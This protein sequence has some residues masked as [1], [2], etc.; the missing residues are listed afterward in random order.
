[1][2]DMF[3]AG[4]D[5]HAAVDAARRGG[6]VVVPRALTDPFRRRLHSEL[7]ELPFE[8][9]PWEVGPVLQEAEACTLRD[10]DPFPVLRSLVCEFG[11]RVRA[12]GREPSDNGRAAIRGLATWRPNEFYVQRYRPGSLGITSH[13]D[14][15]RYRRLIALFTA[16]GWGRLTVRREREGEVLRRFPIRPGSLV[17][18][19]APGLSGFRDARPFHAVEPLGRAERVSVGLRMNMRVAPSR[20]SAGGPAA[21]VGLASGK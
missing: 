17:M 5:L 12:L 1:M 14:G 15:R 11:A 18:L 7:A 21:A 3:V 19:R 2:S 8:P 9:V 10:L 4:L 6:A 16:C 13:M 20:A